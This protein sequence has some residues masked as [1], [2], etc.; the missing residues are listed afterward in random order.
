MGKAKTVTQ[1]NS[2]QEI[3][4][5]RHNERVV[6]NRNTLSKLIDITKFCGMFELPLRG[7]DESVSSTNSGVFYGLVDLESHRHVARNSQWGSGGEDR[8]QRSKTLH[9]FAKI[10]KF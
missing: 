7:H 6:K 5:A 2:G 1:L 3:A 8:P 4:I 9:F 10:T